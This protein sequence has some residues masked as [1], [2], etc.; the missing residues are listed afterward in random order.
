MVFINKKGAK[1]CHVNGKTFPAVTTSIAKQHHAVFTL[2]SSQCFSFSV[3]KHRGLV[4][5]CQ[6]WGKS[7]LK[8][9]MRRSGFQTKRKLYLT[10]KAVDYEQTRKNL[11]L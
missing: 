4:T 9:R 1:S 10:K 6:V 3:L 8:C 2:N 11:N 5:N 7:G